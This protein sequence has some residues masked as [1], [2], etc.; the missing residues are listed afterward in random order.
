MHK[1]QELQGSGGYN[2]DQKVKPLGKGYHQID[3]DFDN[4]DVNLDT[5]INHL[6]NLKQIEM[7]AKIAVGQGIS[8]FDDEY[9]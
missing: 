1:Y 6:D 5:D 8:E 2:I 9:L 3:E 7:A 4:I